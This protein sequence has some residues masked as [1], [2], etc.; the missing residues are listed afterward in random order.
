MDFDQTLSHQIASIQPANKST[1][2]R[3]CSTAT[4]KQVLIIRGSAQ[5]R[6]TRLRIKAFMLIQYFLPLTALKHHGANNLSTRLNSGTQFSTG[7]LLHKSLIRSTSKGVFGL[8]LK[9][10]TTNLRVFSASCESPRL[11]I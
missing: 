11:T 1:L 4:D 10:R 6:K 9:H 5:L 3:I 8:R 7:S 2:G